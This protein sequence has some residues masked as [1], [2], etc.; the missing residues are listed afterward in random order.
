MAKKKVDTPDVIM[1]NLEGELSAAL[2]AMKKTDKLEEKEIYSRIVKNLCE[3]QGVFLRLA[4]DVMFDL[5]D[6]EMP[7][8]I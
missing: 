7:F 8:K 3:S 4:S 1:D 5:D 2:K 6:N